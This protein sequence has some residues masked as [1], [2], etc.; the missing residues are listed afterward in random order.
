MEYEQRNP[1]RIII[2]SGSTIQPTYDIMKMVGTG[3]TFYIFYFHF[4]L[5][6]TRRTVGIFI[7]LYEVLY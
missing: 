3:G 1:E 7:Y 4:N 5:F 2:I 6:R